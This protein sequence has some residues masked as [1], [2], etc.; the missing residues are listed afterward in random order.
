VLIALSAPITPDSVPRGDVRGTF[1]IV[2]PSRPQLAELARLIDAGVVRPFVEAMYPLVQGR[3]A[4]ER[5]VAGHL[6]GKIV[7][8][9]AS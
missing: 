9:V 3:Q 5:V 1:F 2:R 6:A 8:T 7:L 4:F